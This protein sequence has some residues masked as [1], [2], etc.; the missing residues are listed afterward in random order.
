MFVHIR[1]K[2]V[3]WKDGNRLDIGGHCYREAGCLCFRG[4][5]RAVFSLEPASVSGMAGFHALF[6]PSHPRRQVV[7]NSRRNNRTAEGTS[8]MANTETARRLFQANDCLFFDAVKNAKIAFRRSKCANTVVFFFNY[9]CDF[10]SKENEWNEELDWMKVF[11]FF[12]NF[13]IT[14]IFEEFKYII[15]CVHLAII[16]LIS[17]L[18]SYFVLLTSFLIIK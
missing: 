2:I 16:S 10:W 14:S 5:L 4:G 1:S 17:S 13:T 7:I 3:A 11:R 6:T 8:K 18:R 12:G 9:I 15:L